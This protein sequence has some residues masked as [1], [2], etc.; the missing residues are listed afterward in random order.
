M[1]RRKMM[2]MDGEKGE[3]NAKKKGMMISCKIC[4][5][6]VESNRDHLSQ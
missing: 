4:K 2:G 1:V 3:D 5:E 6:V